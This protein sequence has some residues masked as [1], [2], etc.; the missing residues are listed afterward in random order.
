MKK[1]ALRSIVLALPLVIRQAA[2]KHES[3]REK[4]QSGNCVVQLRLRDG[5]VARHYVFRNG[6]VTGFWGRHSRPDTEM[7]FASVDSA[8][9]LM[10]PD[11]DYAVVIDALKTFKAM[12]GGQVGRSA[13]LYSPAA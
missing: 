8:L 3:V 4:L 5:S 11:P 7:V 13:G 12:A 9:A 1:L 2:K 10:R 6:E